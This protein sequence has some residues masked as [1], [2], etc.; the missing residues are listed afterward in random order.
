MSENFEGRPILVQGSEFP[1]I[2]REDCTEPNLFCEGCKKSVLI[3]HHHAKCVVGVGLQCFKCGHVTWSPSLPAGEVFPK[4]VLTLGDKGKFL[5]GSSVKNKKNVVITCDQEI[6]AVAKNTLLRKTPVG[7]FGLSVESIEALTQ[8]LNE[9]SGGS[10]AK[11]IKAAK[12]AVDRGHMYHSANPLAWAF[13]FIRQQLNNN[14]LH[15]HEGTLVA[16]S[17]IQGYTYN[18]HRWKSHAHITHIAKDFCSAFHHTQ[19]QLVA[20]SY[21]S[22]HG[23]NIAI[24]PPPLNK[25]GRFADLYVRVSSS[26]KEKIFIEI[27]T[28]QEIEWPNQMTSI[29]GMKKIVESCLS[30]AKGQIGTKKSGILI[31]G[32]TCL[33]PGF[34]NLF[35]KATESVLRK[36]GRKYSGVAGIGIVGLSDITLKNKSSSSLDFSTSYYVKVVNNMHYFKDNPIKST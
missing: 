22:E 24:N 8:E 15:M 11:P 9:L 16:M 1:I 14:S 17:I 30:K 18:I 2:I 5:I 13:E 33:S 19:T 26:A 6:A 10:F 27:K 28:P 32:A 3:E 31:I 20:A 4:P 23:N 35:E 7:N 12:N 29:K 36:K 25:K 21:L 34:S